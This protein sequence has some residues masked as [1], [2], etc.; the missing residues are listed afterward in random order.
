M[1]T[2]VKDS[3]IFVRCNHWFNSITNTRKELNA[4]VTAL[5]KVRIAMYLREPKN[6]EAFG[7]GNTRL[8][9]GVIQWG[10]RPRLQSTKDIILL[11][12]LWTHLTRSVQGRVQLKMK[13]L[14]DTCIFAKREFGVRLT[15]WISL[16]AASHIR[17]S[18]HSALNLEMLWRAIL[19][20]SSGSVNLPHVPITILIGAAS[21][22]G[23]RFKWSKKFRVYFRRLSKLY[24][25]TH[26]ARV[27]LSPHR[28]SGY[29]NHGFYY[30]KWR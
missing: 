6:N 19:Q 16:R 24:A 13:L 21:V 12:C 7:G 1:Q 11:R 28:M 10:Q 29:N 14:D 4:R 18:P 17:F 9:E 3:Q 20:K 23:S 27:H 22:W 2:L 5:F 25:L 30:V 8:N 26:K 15:Q